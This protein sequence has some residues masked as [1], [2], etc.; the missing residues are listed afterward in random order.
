[1][2]QKTGQQLISTMPLPELIKLM[3]DEVPDTVQ[4][5]AAQLQFVS[6]RCV[7]PAA[8][9]APADEAG[10]SAPRSRAG[11]SDVAENRTSMPGRFGYPLRGG[12][13]ALMSGFLPHL[14]CQL[15]TGARLIRL[16]PQRH[17]ADQLLIAIVA[18][19]GQQ[20][21]VRLRMK[22]D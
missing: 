21:D 16:H 2:W 20:R 22:P 7:R 18:S 4:Q 11:T 9:R 19:V 6:V 12:F 1:M 14:K 10:L 5:A 13:Q 17:S 3:G 8:R 15:E